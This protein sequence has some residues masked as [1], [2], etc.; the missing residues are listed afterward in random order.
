MKKKTSAICLGMIFFVITCVDLYA[1]NGYKDYSWGMTITQVK[2]KCSDLKIYDDTYWPIPSYAIMYIYHDEIESIVPDPLEQEHEAVSA[3][4]SE[5][6]DLKFYFVNKKLVAV[7]LHFSQANILKELEKEYGEISPVDG[8]HG[9][10]RYKTAAW[11]STK[12]VI[13]WDSPGYGMETVTYVDGNWLT[14]LMNKTISAYRKEKDS[15][16]SRLD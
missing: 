9:G 3:Y 5:K 13:V 2:G 16:T 12:R 8:A 15:V 7:E 11:N 4:T 1:Q 6:K 10:Y 14:P